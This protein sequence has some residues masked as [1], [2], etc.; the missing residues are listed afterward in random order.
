MAGFLLAL[1]ILKGN[2]MPGRWAVTNYLFNYDTGF[3]KRALWGE[4]LRRVFGPWTANYFCLA[5]VAIGI[6]GAF[7]ALLWRACR[8]LPA[9]PDTVAFLLVFAASPALAMSAHLVGYL[10]QVG[11]LVLMLTI[12]LRR[13]WQW[14]AGAAIAAAAVLPLVHEN[15]AL[16]L[17]PL[18]A[19]VILTGRAPRR[20]RF[21]AVAAIA[22]LSLAMTGI[23]VKY[24]RVTSRQR[25]DQIRT[26]RTA[27]F[28]F[29]PRQDAFEPLRVP[30]PRSLEDMR[31]RWA[32]P[33]AQADMAYSILV[34]APAAAFLMVL[35]VRQARTL[36]ADAQV[37]A[38]ALVL[39]AAAL[40][41]PLALHVVAW[42]R[43]RWNGLAAL[44]AGLAAL[45]LLQASA[46]RA[47]PADATPARGRRF[48]IAWIVAIWSICA[49]PVFFDL[50]APAHPPFS[51]QIDFLIRAVRHPDRNLWIPTQ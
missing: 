49:H 48:A 21:A 10:E 20:A 19:L 5:F 24:G 38:A 6:F 45:I 13:R 7:L 51:A 18:S 11:Q 25:L 4:I 3:L 2:R 1:T 47:T 22:V 15:S 12:A 9:T 42:D 37:R 43:H 50:Y 33:D 29:R 28:E 36:D 23:V 27:F 8:R 44:N 14:Q 26:E 40:L 16:L 30:L 39:I 35:A 31:V 17:A 46:E 34:F 41:G 32:N